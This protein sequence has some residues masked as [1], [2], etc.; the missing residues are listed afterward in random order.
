M[1]DIEKKLNNGK[2]NGTVNNYW[3]Y[4]IK[5]KKWAAYWT[6]FTE[7][8]FEKVQLDQNHNLSCVTVIPEHMDFTR[9]KC[10]S[11]HPFHS[12]DDCA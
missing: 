9:C 7:H 11:Q 5:G 6:Y 3:S 4:K 10:C 12:E 8:W 2:M 1:L